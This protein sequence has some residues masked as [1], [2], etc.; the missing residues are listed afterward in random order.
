LFVFDKT[1]LEVRYAISM[2]KNHIAEV[3]VI[4][5]VQTKEITKEMIED[6]ELILSSYPLPK[7]IN[8]PNFTVPLIPD[9][10]YLNQLKSQIALLY[11]TLN[12]NRIIGK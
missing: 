6:T 5:I 7:S 1:P 2:I 11:E 3:K 4:K 9:N 8:K 12:D 10:R